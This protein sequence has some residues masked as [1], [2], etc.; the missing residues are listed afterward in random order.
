VE[1]IET[2]SRIGV[3][4]RGSARPREEKQKVVFNEDGVSG[5]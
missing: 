3:R 5:W 1:V 2:D 4:G